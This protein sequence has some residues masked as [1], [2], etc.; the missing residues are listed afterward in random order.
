MG[1]KRRYKATAKRPVSREVL[2][3]YNRHD[4]ITYADLTREQVREAQQALRTR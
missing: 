3:R 4:R 2:D 1:T